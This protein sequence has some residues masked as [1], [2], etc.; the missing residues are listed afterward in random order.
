MNVASRLR[1]HT[2]VTGE[3]LVVSAEL[4]KSAALPPGLSLGTPERITLRG[5]CAPIEVRAARRAQPTVS[6][7]I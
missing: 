6:N 5:R 7:R 2:K 4:L 3:I 1:D